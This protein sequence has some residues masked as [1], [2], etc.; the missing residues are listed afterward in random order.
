MSLT[1]ERT[2]EVALRK[3][4][5]ITHSYTVQPIPSAD[6]RLSEKFLLTLQEKENQFGKT[7]Q[8]HL[9]VSPYVVVQ[10]SKSGKSSSERHRIF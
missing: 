8:K 4:N 1:G 6:G 5:N 10:A 2:T 7:I 9:V 3:K